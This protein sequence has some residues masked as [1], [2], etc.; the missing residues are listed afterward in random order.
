ML[1]GGGRYFLMFR[2]EFISF[3]ERVRDGEVYRKALIFLYTALSKVLG[4]GGGSNFGL[5]MSI[6]KCSENI[7]VMAIC[8]M[9]SSFI[10]AMLS[11]SGGFSVSLDSGRDKISLL[12]V[13]GASSLTVLRSSSE[14]GKLI[15]QT[16][17]A[18]RQFL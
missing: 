8:S 14:L 4:C 10:L 12:S 15:P 11:P 2:S 18:L 6:L 17:S 1:Q 16:L 3:I 5:F 13:C 9:C 7:L